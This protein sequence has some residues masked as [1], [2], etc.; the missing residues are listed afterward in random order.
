LSDVAEALK[1]AMKAGE[2]DKIR[3]LMAA[4]TKLQAD[5]KALDG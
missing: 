2:R 4:R 3:E 1:A 5:M